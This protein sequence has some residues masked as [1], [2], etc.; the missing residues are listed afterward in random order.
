MSHLSR[1]FFILWETL[2]SYT[3]SFVQYSYSGQQCLQLII[4]IHVYEQNN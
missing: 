2:V 3:S 1:V 4:Y